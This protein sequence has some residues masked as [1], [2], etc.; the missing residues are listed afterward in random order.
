MQY[1]LKAHFYS[2]ADVPV[3]KCHSVQY[4]SLNDI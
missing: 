3:S 2:A 1:I 4:L